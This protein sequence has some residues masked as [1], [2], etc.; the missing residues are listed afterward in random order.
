MDSTSTSQTTTSE[1]STKAAPARP[2]IPKGE[3]YDIHGKIVDHQSG[4]GGYS[5]AP[6]YAQYL[7][8]AADGQREW[9][10]LTTYQQ[11]KYP[12]WGCATS[13]PA[14][15]A[16]TYG[17]NSWVLVTSLH[18]HHVVRKLAEEFRH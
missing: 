13:P 18:G 4:G 9:L 11:L 15:Q 17:L 1:P 14:D 5:F 10:T 16:T 6:G 12:C 2:T 7:I 3:T 8:E